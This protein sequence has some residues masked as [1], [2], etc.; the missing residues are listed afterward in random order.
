MTMKIK[1]GFIYATVAAFWGANASAFDDGSVSLAPTPTPTSTG[2]SVGGVAGSAAFHLSGTGPGIA[3]S[4][5]QANT[6]T[7]GSSRGL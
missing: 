4:A 5:A 6:I 1:H 7:C 3:V 2:G